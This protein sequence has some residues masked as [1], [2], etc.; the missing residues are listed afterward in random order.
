[1][2]YRVKCLGGEFN[3]WKHE[4]NCLQ[5]VHLRNAAFV[6]NCGVNVKSLQLC[7]ASMTDTEQRDASK[8]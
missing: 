4:S 3:S 1:M 5:E 2:R 8:I 6:L 7:K